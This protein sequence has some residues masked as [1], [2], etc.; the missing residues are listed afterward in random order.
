[1]PTTPVRRRISLLSRSFIRPLGWVN[2]V[3]PVGLAVEAVE[4]V[5]EDVRD[6]LVAGGFVGPAAGP[7]VGFEGLD[8]GE[9]AGAASAYAVRERGFHPI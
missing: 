8:V 4:V 5:G 2:P 3:R 7:G 1:M 9:L 6:P